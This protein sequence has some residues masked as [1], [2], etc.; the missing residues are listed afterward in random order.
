MKN[1]LFIIAILAF[2]SCGTKT[3]KESNSTKSC[4]TESA[5]N[6]KSKTNLA[7]F[8]TVHGTAGSEAE[9]MQEIMNVQKPV[10]A[11][12]G[13]IAY[14]LFQDTEKPN[15][16]YIYEI[17]STRPA[18][19]KHMKTQHLKDYI[20]VITEKKLT[21]KGSDI[22]LLER[23]D[24]PIPSNSIS[25]SS[26]VLF[27]KITAKESEAKNMQSVIENTLL[28]PTREEQGCTLYDLHKSTS[29]PNE[30]VF[31]EIWESVDAWT[32]H[33][34]NDHLKEFGDKATSLLAK[35][36]DI[37]KAKFVN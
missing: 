9:L 8:V 14:N 26:L 23:N 7:L 22:L 24:R 12:D 36:L 30:F 4:C 21:T 25:P 34:K 3:K 27:A 10:R 37:Y 13:C 16:F 35:D 20:S 11:E 33:M 17:W 2:V 29:S 18:W 31:F 15:I 1:L 5:F 19:E 6:E 28:K 32:A